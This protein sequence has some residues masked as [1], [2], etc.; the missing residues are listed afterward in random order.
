MK[1]FTIDTYRR[2]LAALSLNDRQFLRCK[3]FFGGAPL[4]KPMVILRH[5]VDAKKENSLQFARIQAE[6]GIAATYYFRITSSS[7]DEQVIKEIHEMGHEIGYH[8][9]TMDTCRG[10]V[11][12]AY[13]TFCRELDRFRKFVPVTTICMHGSPLSKFDNRE[14]WQYYDYRLLGIIAEPYFDLNFNKTFYL[15]DTGRCWDGQK[16]SVR[17]KA[18][19][20]N[21]CTNPDF[22]RLSYHSTFDIISAIQNRNFPSEV[23]MTFH[24]QRW[25]NSALPWYTELITQTLKNEVKR[26]LVAGKKAKNQ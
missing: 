1:D 19:K 10:N 16:V 8:Y 4:Q 7:Y 11:K 12:Q 20:F 2:L 9:E 13:D 14:I 22:L 24:P 6:M 23:M 3:D 15:T 5:D 25:T 26:V 18:A 21:L 17:D